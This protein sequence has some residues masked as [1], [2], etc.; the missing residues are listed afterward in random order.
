MSK[1]AG[2]RVLR[3]GAETQRSQRNSFVCFLA[4]PARPLPLLTSPFPP[5]ATCPNDCSGRGLCRTLTDIATAGKPVFV[6]SLAGTNVYTGF[7]RPYDYRLWDAQQGTACVCDP[8][9]GGS[10]CSLRQ[11]PMGND[12]L[13]TTPQTC[14]GKK[15][16]NEY[17]AFSVDGNQGKYSAIDGSVVS[18]PGT[19]RI[20]FTDFTG[21]KY[22][23][24]EFQLTTWATLT[25]NAS[26]VATQTQNEMNVK[27]A[28]EALPNNVTGQVVVTTDATYQGGPAEKN[29]YRLGV[30]FAT[31]SGNIP[32]MQVIWDGV[33]NAATKR[34]YVFQPGSPVTKFYYPAVVTASDPL[35]AS[36]VVYPVDQTLY[37]LNRYWLGVQSSTGQS[38]RSGTLTDPS[39]AHTTALA[40]AETAI[41]SALN[42]IPAVVKDLGAPFAGDRNVIAESVT[43]IG[44][45]QFIPVRVA[46]PSKQFGGNKIEYFFCAN[47]DKTGMCKAGSSFGTT[48]ST[49]STLQTDGS[50]AYAVSL[51][52]VS[53]GNQEYVTCSNRG[54]CDYS[55][56]LCKCFSGYTSVACGTQS[57]L[58][59]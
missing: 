28:L 26:G 42:A 33:S 8:G 49:T 11:C 44:G 29:Q 34:S 15:C 46:M 59:K 48:V 50:P 38:A 40:A 3:V 7:S 37:G 52:D 5:A 47:S 19:Y 51:G 39:A 58:A 12:P 23:T 32:D 9:Y 35:F 17:Q 41:A 57:T 36:I 21:I 14:G 16:Q 24:D 2:Q 4:T 27:I 45:A 22:T 53:D 25:T 31:K 10:D 6:E 20:V 13:T 55:S 1:Y 18:L 30:Y 54:I 56:G 43:T